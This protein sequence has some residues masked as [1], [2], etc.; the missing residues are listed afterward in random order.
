MCLILY[1]YWTLLA[2]T[3][4]Y[5]AHTCTKLSNRHKPRANAISP[6]HMENTPRWRLPPQDYIKQH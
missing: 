5:A 3:V 6:G 1:F 2:E 4:P